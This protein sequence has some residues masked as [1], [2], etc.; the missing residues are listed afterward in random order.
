M[1]QQTNQ[2]HMK[3][4]LAILVLALF[5]GG[6]AAPA[7]ASVNHDQIV[8]TDEEPKKKEKKAEKKKATKS[9][10]DC[11]DAKKSECCDKKAKAETDK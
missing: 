5:I 2:M 1:Q 6:V 9:S 7:I 11:S 8:L 4:I 3:K 10:S